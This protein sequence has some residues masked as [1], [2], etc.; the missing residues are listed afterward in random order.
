[1]KPAKSQFTKPSW[2]GWIHLGAFP[3]SIALGTLLVFVA[4]GAGAKLAC[5]VFSLCSS[6]L[7]GLSATYHRFEWRV[8][9]APII[10]RL[11]HSNIFLFIAGTYTPIAWGALPPDKS[12][13]LL[14]LVW[15]FALV[16][17][18]IRLI[19]LGAPRWSYVL[20]YVAL[21]WTAIAYVRELYSASAAALLLI[22]L[23][24]IIYS[25]G[26]LVYAL[27]QP[28]PIPKHFGFHEI[29]HL[30]TVVAFLCHWTAVYLITTD[31]LVFG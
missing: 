9:V 24:G 29:F 15:S 17:I 11:D 4:E 19:W 3:L 2:R 7:F 30:L 10:R 18:L 8:D 22:V 25:A 5:S 14:V 1:M 28:D 13:F 26:A 27:R 31:P 6:F 12:I 23:G 16:G 20:M 21:G